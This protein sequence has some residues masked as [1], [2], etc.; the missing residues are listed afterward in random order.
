MFLP[1]FHRFKPCMACNASYHGTLLECPRL[2]SE[3]NEMI[4]SIINTDGTIFLGLGI[5]RITKKEDIYVDY[6]QS[7]VGGPFECKCKTEKEKI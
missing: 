2:S 1:F 7:P 6:I 3:P 5:Y 4:P